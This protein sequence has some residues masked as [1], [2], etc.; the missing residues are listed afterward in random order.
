MQVYFTKMHGTGN[1]FVFIEDMRSQ[2]EL[3]QE[4]IQLL[5]DRHMGVG[6]DGVILVRP[7]K[8][9]QAVAYMHYINSDGTLAQMCGNGVRCF[10]KYLVDNQLVLPDEDCFTVETL[11]GLKEITV[12]RDE[13]GHMLTACVD[14]GIPSFSRESLPTTLEYT[15]NDESFGNII[16]DTPIE[17]P[18]GSFDFTCVSMGNP[19]AIT[20]IDDPSAFD[21]DGNGSFMESNPL[22]PERVNTEFAHVDQVD[23]DKATISMR[24]FER[25]CGETLACGTGCCA[26]AV[27]AAVTGRAP[28]HSTLKILGGELDIYW[29]DNGHVFMTGPATTVYDGK[30]DIVSLEGSGCSCNCSC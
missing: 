27:A 14:M 23:N 25:G 26:T 22:F 7:A 29:R 11:S 10:A 17:L 18:D 13:K 2:L 5:C 20:F 9:D 3:S 24:V 6:A 21:I 30:I 8:D 4:D 19:H 15:V 1:D 12:T 16:A 28:R